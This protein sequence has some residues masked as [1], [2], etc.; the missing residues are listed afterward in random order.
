MQIQTD[1]SYIRM[2]FNMLEGCFDDPQ[3]AVCPDIFARV[4]DTP[5]LQYSGALLPLMA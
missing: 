1:Y 3:P 2:F 5:A 4:L